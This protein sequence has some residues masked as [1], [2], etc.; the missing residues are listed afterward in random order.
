MDKK[1]PPALAVA[2]N[3][4]LVYVI[5]ALCRV[6]YVLENWHLFSAGF[7]D[8]SMGSL[9]RGAF[10]FDTISLLYFNLPFLLM[11]F[12]PLRIKE[13][14]K[15]YSVQKILFVVLNSISAFMNVADSAY[16]P[17]TGKR[18]TT[19]VFSEF[20]NESNTVSILLLETAR[21][22]Y[23]VLF[24]IAVVVSYWK[25]YQQPCQRKTPAI[26]YYL[27]QCMGMLFTALFFFF[28][29]RGS[30]TIDTRP[31][32]LRDANIYV[33]KP[34]QT[35]IVLNT[36]FSLI[37]SIGH[38]GFRDPK[39]FDR[40][41]LDSA[42]TP[43]HIPAD[44]AEF[45][46]KNVVVIIS[47]SLGREYIG[48]YNKNLDSGSYKGYTPFLDSLI[49]E[50]LTF[51]YTFA[52][53]RKSIDAMPS[54]LSSLPMIENNFF[55]TPYINNTIGGLSV[56]LCGKGYNTSFFHG[57]DNGSMGFDS[58]SRAISYHKYYG[59]DEYNADPEFGGDA[60]YDGRW[61]IWD[62]N[63]MEFWQKKL[64]ETPEPF[65]STIFT[66]SSHHPFKIPEAFRDTF[67]EEALPMHKCIR[68]VD[69]CYRKFFEHASRQP[70][71]K[72]T[73]FVI[74]GDHTN[75][76]NH[77][78]YQ[79][80]L[81][82]YCVPVIFYD[83]SG[84]LPRGVM[85]GM[86]QQIDIMPTILGMLHYDEPYVAY[87]RDLLS[88]DSTNQWALSFIDGTYQYLMGDFV[89]Q[90]DGS[91]PKALY[92]YR[93][94][95]MLADNILESNDSLSAVMTTRLRMMIQCYVER[96]IENRLTDTK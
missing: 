76:T 46:P 19:T 21:H 74:T 42:Y 40:Q 77:A 83:P 93:K 95:W 39:Y 81:G 58:Y 28:G 66:A 73:I 30:L 12:L 14:P 38:S 48:F 89:L 63:F 96:M 33:D 55:A 29:I 61:A 43:V 41:W 67:P 53:G 88:A 70:W 72:K 22:W 50:S 47:E 13:N 86:A 85:Q 64:D 54:I 6:V 15:Y 52:N 23:L 25:L 57:A 17:Y 82:F 71:F 35:A 92:N 31:K 68:Y 51:E 4:L 7:G 90:Y 62:G 10:V 56:C 11:T 69:H 36:P 16:F 60:D 5:S 20:A 80:D 3:L 34:S 27:T 78:E 65:L 75:Q 32:G 2:C 18:T 37:R 49:G 44:G 9:L 59:R 94:D 26:S 87:G 84:Q 91:N 24:V 8:L 79:T 45:C 1:I